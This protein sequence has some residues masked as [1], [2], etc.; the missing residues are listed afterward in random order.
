[1]GHLCDVGIADARLGS[2]QVLDGDA[3]RVDGGFHLVLRRTQLR[4]LVRH[5]VDGRVDGGQQDVRLR[6]GGEGGV[7]H[8]QVVEVGGTART[9]RRGLDVGEADDHVVAG[10]WTHAEGGV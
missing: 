2:A 9:E 5:L 6:D 7:V 1:R 3:Q 8:D 10:V 4:A